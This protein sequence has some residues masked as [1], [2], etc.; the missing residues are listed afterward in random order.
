[1]RPLD[2]ARAPFR[3]NG[4]PL[5]AVQVTT[6]QVVPY[7]F[8]GPSRNVYATGY[9]VCFQHRRVLAWQGIASINTQQSAFA[10]CDSWR[11]TECE[12]VTGAWAMC[13]ASRARTSNSTITW[14]RWCGDDE[15]L[16][17]TLGERSLT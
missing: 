14:W 6:T 2:T 16:L 10:E 1:M 3:T 5:N 7:F 9:C 17:G 8:V 15:A 11:F 13:R 12:R 4:N